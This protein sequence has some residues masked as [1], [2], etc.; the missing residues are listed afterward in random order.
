MNLCTGENEKNFKK[1]W[2]L[3]K[4]QISVKEVFIL[5]F[6]GQWINSKKNKWYQFY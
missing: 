2:I 6:D 5:Y 3:F 4:K 1:Y